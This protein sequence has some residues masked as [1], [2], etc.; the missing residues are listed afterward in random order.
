MAVPPSPSHCP[1]RGIALFKA[2]IVK[3]MR[4]HQQAEK[5]SLAQLKRQ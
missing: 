3:S 5:K 4:A 2:S 1:R